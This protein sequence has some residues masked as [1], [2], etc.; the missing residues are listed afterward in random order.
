MSLRNAVIDGAIRV[1]DELREDEPQQER[2]ERPKEPEVPTAI[3]I[4]GGLVRD[5]V[6]DEL[7]RREQRDRR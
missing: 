5:Q 1:L 6:R 4:I 2:Q 3:T 7:R